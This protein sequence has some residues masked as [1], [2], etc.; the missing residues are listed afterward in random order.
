ME[1][2]H[3][4]RKVSCLIIRARPTVLLKPKARKGNIE[5]GSNRQIRFANNGPIKRVRWETR[6]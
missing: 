5:V 3:S 4:G 2:E 1:L 6:A